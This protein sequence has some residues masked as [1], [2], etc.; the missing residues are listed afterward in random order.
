MGCL[1]QQAQPQVPEL[2]EHWNT[3]LTYRGWILGG[4]VW[5]WRLDSMFLEVPSKLGYSMILCCFI[6]LC[7]THITREMKFWFPISVKV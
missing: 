2:M 3:I 4:P 6:A 1:G 5:S 7:H